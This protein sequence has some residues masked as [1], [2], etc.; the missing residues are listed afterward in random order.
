[1][2]DGSDVP[3]TGNLF[4]PVKL[5]LRIRC[6]TR[7]WQTY[8]PKRVVVQ[9]CW[10]ERKG[11]VAPKIAK[12][13][14]LS[15]PNPRWVNLTCHTCPLF[16]SVC[17]VNGEP[18]IWWTYCREYTSL[19]RPRYPCHLFEITTALVFQYLPAH[20]DVVVPGL[21]VDLM[22]PRR[23]APAISVITSIGLEHKFSPG[24]YDRT[25]CLGKGG[26]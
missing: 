4:H 25:D 16:G 14:E 15:N 24:R 22:Q 26:L 21:V 10:N 6:C 7:C 5:G 11:S 9:Y 1:M 18:I 13:I 3:A 2:N 19:C 23:K 17:K 8:D 12:S 20:L